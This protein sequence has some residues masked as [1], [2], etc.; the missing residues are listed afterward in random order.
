ML[1]VQ[2]AT[3]RDYEEMRSAIALEKRSA[4]D[5]TGWILSNYRFQGGGRVWLDS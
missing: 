4:N 1:A 3:E 5:T 2:R